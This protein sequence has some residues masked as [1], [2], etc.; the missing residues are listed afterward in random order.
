MAAAANTLLIKPML[1]WCGGCRNLVARFAMPNAC[2]RR[3]RRRRG[4]LRWRPGAGGRGFED[5]RHGD[6]VG[7][8]G[9]GLGYSWVASEVLKA[10]H[11]QWPVPDYPRVFRAVGPAGAG[12][13]RRGGAPLAASGPWAVRADRPRTAS[14]ALTRVPPLFPPRVRA[15][16]RQGSEMQDRASVAAPEPSPG[17]PWRSSTCTRA[18]RCRWRRCLC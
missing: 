14:A 10:D 7:V 12:R 1:N 4:W 2:R 6:G 8:R 13:G 3:C 17:L 18:G 9:R 11:S 5:S 15:P 16:A